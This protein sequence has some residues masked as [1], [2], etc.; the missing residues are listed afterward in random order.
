[1]V[2][3][4]GKVTEKG[5][6]V[7]DADVKDG[8]LVVRVRDTGVGIDDDVRARLFLPFTQA[9]ASITRRFGGTGLGLAISQRLAQ[10]MH[11]TIAAEGATGRGS[12]FP[13]T[14]PA[15]VV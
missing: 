11:G 12:T 15:V 4:A 1:L 2:S 6:V 3:N 9:D 5:E 14:L 10:L 7:V 13:L 8:A